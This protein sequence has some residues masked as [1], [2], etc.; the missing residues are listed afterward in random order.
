MPEQS[1]P[2]AP[3]RPA[4]SIHGRELFHCIECW[5]F[6]EKLCQLILRRA[7]KTAALSDILKPAAEGY[8]QPEE[9]AR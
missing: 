8:G 6:S 9:G 7:P 5:E 2:E 3:I 1:L 4:R